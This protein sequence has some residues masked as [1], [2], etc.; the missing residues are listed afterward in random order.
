MEEY[1]VSIHKSKGRQENEKTGNYKVNYENIEAQNKT[2][3][4]NTLKKAQINVTKSQDKTQNEKVKQGDKITYTITA[5]NSGNDDGKVII[6][7]IKPANCKNVSA[8]I[9]ANEN[10]VKDAG[11][12]SVDL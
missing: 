5:Q 9:D 3:I 11:E 6:K 10:K 12:A 1:T 2:K 8:W 7:D 4:T